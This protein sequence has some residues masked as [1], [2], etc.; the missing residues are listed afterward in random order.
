M[1]EQNASFRMAVAGA[2][3]GA[4]AVPM[5][6][7]RREIEEALAE[8][9]GGAEMTLVVE[10]RGD[11]VESH[12]V[13]I[14]WERDDLARLLSETTGDDVTVLLNGEELRGAVE[15]ADVEGHSLRSTAAVVSVILATAVA[16]PAAQAQLDQG[17]GGP[18]A[19]TSTG[20]AL[21]HDQQAPRPLPPQQESA[22]TFVHDQQEPRPIAQS[23]PAATFVHDQQE[24]RPVGPAAATPTFVHDQQD[25][26]PIAPETPRAAFVHDQQDPRPITPDAPR[27][28][29]VHDQQDP[30]PIAPDAP[31]AAFV[32]DQQDPRPITPS[33]PATV[34]PAPDPDSPTAAAIAAI[35]GAAGLAVAAAAFTSR[36]RER[37]TAT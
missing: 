3:V 31:R 6:L 12:Q 1:A 36:R 32:H 30:R 15:G 27:A 23:Q 21:I 25:P 37:P 14:A 34:S 20:A 35:A 7:S 24:P 8:A 9:N 13:R 28:A 11:D 19:T 18:S 33:Q 5:H 4:S 22:A 2:F 16:A 26:R 29:F 17:T 10:S